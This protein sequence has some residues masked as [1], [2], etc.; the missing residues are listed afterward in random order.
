[1]INLILYCIVYRYLYSASHSTRKTEALFSAF[2]LQ[3]KVRPEKDEERGREI[4]EER[5]GGERRFPERTWNNRCEGPG[6]DHTRKKNIMAT[7]YRRTERAERRG[8][9]EEEV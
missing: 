9:E 7:I 1:M 4:I 3:E 2:Q 5:R 8:R 6:L